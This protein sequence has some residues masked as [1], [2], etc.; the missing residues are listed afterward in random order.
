MEKIPM[1][2][3]RKSLTLAAMALAASVWG[4]DV[5]AHPLALIDATFSDGTSVTG[6]FDLNVY[7]FVDNSSVSITTLPSGSF[8]GFTYTFGSIVPS[9]PPASGIDL[10]GFDGTVNR[11]LHIVFT[12]AL[13]QSGQDDIDTAASWECLGFSCPPGSASGPNIR[14]LASGSTFVPEP[15]SLSLLAIG[16]FAL[17][18]RQ[19]KVEYPL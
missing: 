6:S 15:S 14:Y 10:T 17:R 2:S 4:G 18:R 19:A 16:A 5:S 11:E 12:H 7:G 1:Q 3:P 13:N 8:T 9:T